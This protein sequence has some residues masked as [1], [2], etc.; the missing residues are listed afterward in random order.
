MPIKPTWIHYLPEVGKPLTSQAENVDNIMQEANRLRKKADAMETYYH[1][2]L[3]DLATL[4]ED[5]W[6][7]DEI[8]KAKTQYQK[9]NS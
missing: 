8:G 4:V 7:S 6:A 3:E 5:N 2:R 9:D 1:K